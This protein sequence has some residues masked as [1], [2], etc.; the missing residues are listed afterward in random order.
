MKS[1]RQ[2]KK[3][4]ETDLDSIAYEVNELVSAPSVMILTG[5]LGAGKTTFSRSFAKLVNGEGAPEVASPTYSVMNEMGVLV[6]A[7]FYRIKDPEEI[8]H[9]EIPLYLDDK[10]FF[11]VEWGKKYLSDLKEEVFNEFEF[12]ELVFQKEE[13]EG[14]RSLELFELGG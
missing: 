11:L 3:A 12:F 2:W 9:L 6:H 10:D 7:D 4:M 14:L 5:D 13:G 1:L 8:L